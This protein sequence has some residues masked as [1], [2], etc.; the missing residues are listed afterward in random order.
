[1]KFGENAQ[2]VKGKIYAMQVRGRLVVKLPKERV[3]KL[4]AAGEAEPFDPGHGRLMKEWAVILRDDDG[5]EL[6][7]EARA[8]V[9]EQQRS[10]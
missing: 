10:R 7:R 6:A 2:K 8:F 3:A 9:L 1:V 5:G 4:V